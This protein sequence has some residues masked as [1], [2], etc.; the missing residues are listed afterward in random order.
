VKITTIRTEPVTK[1][2]MSLR[3]LLDRYVTDLKDG[4]IVAVTSK[5]VSLCEDKGVAVGTVDVQELARKEAE[6]YLAPGNNLGYALTVNRGILTS[7]AGVDESNTGG[8]Y[9]PWPDDPQKSANDAREYLAKKFGVRVGVIITDG[10]VTPMRRGVIGIGLSHSGFLALHN[11]VGQKDIFGTYEL[12]YTYDGVLD[13]LAAAAA[14]QMGEGDQ[15]RPIAIIEDADFVEFQDRNP[16]KD[17]L[18][19]LNI[20]LEDDL[21]AEMLKG[22]AWDKRPEGR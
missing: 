5:V 11:L 20:D 10:R 8:Y 4:S 2:A 14:V 7:K 9:V 18:A 21:F 16:T 6:Y 17:E 3:E 13:G 12:K 15:C 1:G 22:I 19:L